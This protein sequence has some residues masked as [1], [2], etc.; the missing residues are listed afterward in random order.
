MKIKILGFIYLTRNQFVILE[1]ILF[2]FFFLLT[3]FFFAWTVPEYVNDPLVLFHARYLKYVTLVL[4]FLIVVETQ[5]YLNKFIEKQ[6]EINEL[7]RKKI[8][9]QN[10]EIMQSI[11]Y[12]SRIQE[13]I[14]PDI[15]KLPE[16]L[17]HFIFYKPKDIVSGDFYWFAQHYNKTVIVAGDCTGHGVPG[18]FMSVLGISSLNDIINETEQE[19]KSGEILDILKD[20]IITSLK[21]DAEDAISV[22]G[23]DLSIIILDTKT[24]EIQFSGAKNPI[25]IVKNKKNLR[26]FENSDYTITDSE[27]HILFHFKPDK[28]HIGLHPIIQPFKTQNIKLEKDDTIYMFSD[29]FV[30]QMGGVKGKKLMNKRFKNMI[31]NIQNK[32]MK[33]QKDIVERFFYQWKG[34][35]EQTDDVILIGIKI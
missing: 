4:S 12:A 22:S 9:L 2:S 11:R 21:Q 34:N 17:K 3:V 5:Y 13:A 29:G 25:F 1:T 32:S 8:E 16:N 30:D 26:D 20:K 7:Q 19:L 28:M 14:L 6:L 31:L 27:N 24:N 35:Y 23:I 10:D 18:A 15:N 33:E